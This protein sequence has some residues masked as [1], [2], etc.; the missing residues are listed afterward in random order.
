MGGQ[1]FRFPLRES[2]GRFV[3]LDDLIGQHLKALLRLAIPVRDTEE[4][5]I[6]GYRLLNA[7]SVEHTLF[8]DGP[9]GGCDLSPFPHLMDFCEPRL[10]YIKGLVESLSCFIEFE[11]NGNIVP[12]D[13]F[14]LKD[15]SHWL[16]PGG[17][18]GDILALAASRCNLKCL[19]C[20]N[21]G[22]PP[23]LSSKPRDPEIE[24]QEILQRINQYVPQGRLHIFPGVP[25]PCEFLAHP[26]IIDI[27]RALRRKTAEPLR[28]ATNGSLLTSDMIELLK[29][30][31][32]LSLD[33][34]LNSS[35]I[36]R[37]RYLMR[38]PH[39]QVA[40]NSLDG[41]AEA[42]I[43][44]SVVIVPWPF[45][46]S[47]IMLED[48]V[49]TVL[50]TDSREPAFIQISL[51][52]YSRLFSDQILFS[53]EEVWGCLK[54]KTLQL[55]EQVRSPIVMRP[56]LFEDYE[57]PEKVNSTMVIGAVR[58]SPAACA[59]IERGDEILKINGLR[60]KSRHQARSLLTVLHTSTLKETSISI[61]RQDEMLDLPVNLSHHRYPY[62]RQTAT[63]L[64][65]VFS[66]SGIP[67]EWAESLYKT[68]MA[69]GARKVLVLTSLLV[70][71]SF[72]KLLAGSMLPPDIEVHVRIPEN[73]YW[74]G[75]IFMGDLLVV[76]D[77]IDE[78]KRFVREERIYPD[79]VTI[80][81]S[82]FHLSGW[83]R[84]LTG[85]IYLEI[86]Q[87]TGIQ[88]ALMQCNPLFD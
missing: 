65:I 60:V 62:A 53:H 20:Y 40:I 77:F 54:R 15:L 70:A 27:L 18:A 1:V 13:G 23:A 37:R 66:S 45:P 88:V 22:A 83:G 46:S 68:I 44:F 35:S 33:V 21:R 79:L 17:G 56:G 16:V 39:P 57:D 81:S 67:L 86:E 47:E 34:S 10:E 59:G 11:S 42:Q 24:Y 63:H 6:S 58:N 76:Q 52:G 74:G 82:P 48:L 43:P 9:H 72:R 78:V 12:I 29:E 85:R 8:E 3:S 49:E 55:R 50:F 80:P 2:R 73:R 19:F 5:R 41:L 28:I 38:D 87:Q 25:G 51:P 36:E 75:N 32:P 31:K 84:D 64:G 71:P 7:P 14:R 4:V 69:C 30:F 61:K 26:R